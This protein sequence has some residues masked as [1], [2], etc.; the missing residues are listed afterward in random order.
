MKEIETLVEEKKKD[1][2]DVAKMVAPQPG[3]PQ[4]QEDDIRVS[5]TEK[6]LNGSQRVLL[7]KVIS[8]DECRELQRLSNAAALKGDGY[9]GTPSPH[10]PGEMFQ[11]VTVLKALKLGQ[12]GKVPLKSARAFFDVS[13]KARKI[14]ELYFQLKTPLYFSYSHL[15]CRSAIDEKQEA[16]TDLSHPVH[17]DNCLLVSEMNE[18]IKEPPAYTH[19]DYSAILYL[20]DDF[21]GGDFIFTKLDAKTVT[22]EI[23]PQC[24]RMVGFGAGKENP[25]GVRAVT[26]G[27]RCAVALWFTLDP[28]HEEKERIQ[29][30]E[31]L[32]M[33][34]APVNQE[35]IK[36][37]W[38]QRLT[39][40]HQSPLDKRE[41]RRNKKKNQRK[42]NQMQQQLSRKT[43]RQRS[44]QERNQQP[45]LL[46]KPN[47][48]AKLQQR[49]RQKPRRQTKK[50]Q[51]QLLK[52]QL[53]L[54]P[55]VAK[56][57][58]EQFQALRAAKRSSDVTAPTTGR[59]VFFY[60]FSA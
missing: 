10:S 13:E 41:Q 29:A 39:L 52:R 56:Q 4:V 24:G 1:S 53:K 46:P 57:E 11:G 45:K 26:K 35:F 43:S 9:R 48:R 31:M 32:K 58:V 18:C 8:E 22:A 7:D 30:Q 25:H 37:K 49:P 50:T 17:A 23:R 59:A 5:M 14:L 38:P 34:S 16:R 44:K 60:C 33:F 12:E 36:M 27:Q 28:A 2:S 19:R 40:Q 20:N 51:S 54:P 47:P 3:V 42:S 6:Q 15:V 21:E 55:R